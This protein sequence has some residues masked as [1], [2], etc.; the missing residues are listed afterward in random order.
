M[1]IKFKMPSLGDNSKSKGIFR[2]IALTTIATSIS[3][4]LTFGTAH[5][6]E[7]KQKRTAGRQ[8]AMM[9]IH[10]ME[11]S[12][13][14]L[15]DMV[16]DEEKYRKLTE[17]VLE[18]MEN[19]DSLDVDTAW[20]V[21]FYISSSTDKL[22]LY[23]LDESSER[24][25]LSSQDSW[26]NIDNAAFIDAVQEFYTYRHE[27]YDYINASDQWQKPISSDVLYQHQLN[28]EDASTNIHELLK[29]TL[30]SKEVRYYLNYSNGRQTQLN[31]FADQMQHFSD[32]C[33]FNM[34]ITDEELEEY[35]RKTKRTGRDLKEGELIGQWI[36]V[37]TDEKSSSI[38]FFK[39]HTYTQTSITHLSHPMYNGRI[40]LKYTSKGTWRL[41][42]DTLCVVL[43]PQFKFS[44]D[45]SQITPKPGHEQDMKKIIEQYRKYGQ[46]QEL[47]SGKGK[48]R[49]RSYAATISP[50]GNKIELKWKEPDNNQEMSMYLSRDNH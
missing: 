44:I 23:T 30:P 24:V 21:F 14:N 43:H 42:D 38:E 48:E 29:E 33:K 3:I 28:H 36:Q 47:S 2:E 4:I 39:D 26:K 5:F 35:V 34:G 41:N 10:D 1:N 25:F 18:H 20:Q 15:R 16:K 19:F 27:V 31:Q 8:T 45:H 49:P 32:V 12:I 7:M 17:E 11:N 46:Q 50:S 37:S 22:K 9:V 40:D 6:V 13:K